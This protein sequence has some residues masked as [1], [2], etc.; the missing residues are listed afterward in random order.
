[1][2]NALYGIPKAVRKPVL[3]YNKDLIDKPLD[4]LQAGWTTLENPAL[5]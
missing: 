2:D 3:I 1:M 4:S 5:E